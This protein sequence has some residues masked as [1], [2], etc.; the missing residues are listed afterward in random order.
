MI[1]LHYMNPSI[2]LGDHSVFGIAVCMRFKI[3]I[4]V[5]FAFDVTV[6]VTMFA[7]HCV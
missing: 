4:Y 6:K 1:A 7:K 3:D 2:A 5:A